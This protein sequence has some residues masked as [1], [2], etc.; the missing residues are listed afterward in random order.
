VNIVV[1]IDGSL[2]ARHALSA[3]LNL[4]DELREPPAIHAVAVADYVTLPAG[5]DKAP[6]GAPDL[7]SSEA[8]TALAVATELARA[9][10]RTLECHVL[11]GP[12]VREVLAYAEKIGAAMVAVGTHGRKGIRRAL[13]GSTCEALLRESTI[14]VLAVHLAETP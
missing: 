3:V 14:P 5:L 2:G 4:A 9:R 13:L 12:A 10:H 7:L 6:S 11:H 1:A 8:E